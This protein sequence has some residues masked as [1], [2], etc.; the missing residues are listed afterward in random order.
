M[1]SSK[2][3]GSHTAISGGGD[4]V[5]YSDT[6]KKYKKSERGEFYDTP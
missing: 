4:A 1:I 2:H 5:S 3:Q 6:L